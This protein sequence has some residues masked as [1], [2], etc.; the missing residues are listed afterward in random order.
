MAKFDL[1]L[2]GFD[3]F[4][5]RVDPKKFDKRIRRRVEL[6]TKKN[7]LVAEGA[8]KRAINSGQFDRNSVIT[9]AMKGSSRPLVDTGALVASINH[10]V[11][12]WD[13]AFIGVLRSRKV[14]RKGKGKARAYDILNVAF[15]LHEGASI[16]V[17]PKMRRFFAAMARENPGQ[18]FPIRKGTSVIQIPR[19]PFLEA[20][21]EDSRLAL[22]YRRNWEDAVQR[23]LSGT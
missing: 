1:V 17:T 23:A 19:R 10:D 9:I 8:I 5:D 13:V 16:K 21:F 4:K 20:A 15:V 6:A 2:E 22:K 11:P 12:K 7:A 18:W 14:P 3:E